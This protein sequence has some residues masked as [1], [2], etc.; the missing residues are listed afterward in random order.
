MREKAAQSLSRRS[1]SNRT[2]ALQPQPPKGAPQ[3]P[4]GRNITRPRPTLTNCRWAY[5]SY[6]SLGDAADFAV[7]AGRDAND[8]QGLLWKA[9]LDMLL[10]WLFGQQRQSL[11]F[12]CKNRN[13]TSL[14]VLVN[15]LQ[16]HLV[17]ASSTLFHQCFVLLCFKCLTR[18]SLLNPSCAVHKRIICFGGRWII[19]IAIIFRR[20][21]SRRERDGR[22]RIG[23]G[24]CDGSAAKNEDLA[25]DDTTK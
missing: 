10:H 7:V 8:E 15:T 2:Q 1:G 6:T 18:I 20:N 11:P 13:F 3:H 23:A 22:R 4:N 9:V 16:F 21:R 24:S 17:A 25:L 19:W 5:L 14:I 12:R